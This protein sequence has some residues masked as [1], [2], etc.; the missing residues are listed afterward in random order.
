MRLVFAALIALSSVACASDAQ[1]KNAA[2]ITDIAR[3]LRDRYDDPQVI[4]L[5]S[6]ALENEKT[7]R[8]PSARINPFSE[9]EIRENIKASGNDRGHSDWAAMI[10]FVACFAS[11]VYCLAI[12]YY[13]ARGLRNAD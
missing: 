8:V 3:C 6:A 9:I 13:T 5:V 1:S 4:V 2:V 10:A 7:F 11:V 12:V